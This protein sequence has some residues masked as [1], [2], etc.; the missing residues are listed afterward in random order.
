MV[1]IAR[2]DEKPTRL[3]T[4]QDMTCDSDG[5]IA[6]FISP[7]GVATSLPVHPLKS[8]EPYYIGVFL[9]G[10][11]QEILGDMHNLFGDTN[12]VHIDCYKDHYEIDQVIDGETV[13]EVLDY[14]QF[15]PKKL[16]RNVETW[17]TRAM[18][19]GRITPE[20]GREFLSNYRSGLYGY[21]YLEKD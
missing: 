7:Q 14:V 5:K 3:A 10:A 9:V 16:V 11:Y 15:N 8:G 17:V 12:A 6:Y 13:A 4:L 21:T 18:K 20:E 19:E 2:L 1:P